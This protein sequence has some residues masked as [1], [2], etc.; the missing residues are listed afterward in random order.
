VLNAGRDAGRDMTGFDNVLCHHMNINEDADAALADAKRYLDGY[1][2]ANYTTERLRS[3][4]V[5]GRPVHCIEALRAF[6]GSG[7]RRHYLPPGD[8][9]RRHDPVPAIDRGDPAVRDRLIP[10]AA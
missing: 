8:D 9:R 7:C 4:G 1:Y 5:Y 6:I 10:A 2:N 3:W